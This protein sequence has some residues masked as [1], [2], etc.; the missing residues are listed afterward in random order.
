MISIEHRWK[1]EEIRYVKELI[2][3]GEGGMG[4]LLE[5]AKQYVAQRSGGSPTDPEEVQ[6]VYTLVVEEIRK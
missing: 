4:Q 5:D 2:D 3:Q 6:R 1:N